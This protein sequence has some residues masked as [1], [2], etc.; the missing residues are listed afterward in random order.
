MRSMYFSWNPSPARVNL[1]PLL[2]KRHDN[3]AHLPETGK[4]GALEASDFPPSDRRLAP[5][6]VTR[7][8]TC[9]TAFIADAI[10]MRSLR[11]FPPRSLLTYA[12]SALSHVGGSAMDAV[13][14]TAVHPPR[15][16]L[17]P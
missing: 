10:V 8:Y 16:P 5:P 7:G 17:K 13:G 2:G 6:R 12:L 3:N 1:C 4:S 14:G 9:Q 11:A 15:N